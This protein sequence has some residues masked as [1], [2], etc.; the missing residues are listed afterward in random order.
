[1]K[2]NSYK[3]FIKFVFFLLPLS[4]ISQSAGEST[5]QFL[6]IPVSPRQ[7]ALGGKTITTFDNDVSMALYNPS[8]INAE[9][10]NIFSFN[11]W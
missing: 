2:V 3:F 8:T 7:L 11:Y 10:D 6:N 1:M 4:I 5:Y 9:M